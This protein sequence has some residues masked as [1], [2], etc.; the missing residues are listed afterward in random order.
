MKLYRCNPNYLHP[1]FEIVI[2]PDCISGWN[3]IQDGVTPRIELNVSGIQYTLFANE[4]HNVRKIEREILSMINKNH[5]DI[6]A[7]FEKIN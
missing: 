4:Q 1:T 3:L 6:S 2:N 5:S 7:Y